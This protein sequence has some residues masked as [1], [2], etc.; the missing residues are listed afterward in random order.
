MDLRKLNNYLKREFIGS[1]ALKDAHVLDMGCGAGGDF[2]KWREALVGH[3]V[4]ADPSSGAIAEARKRRHHGPD[5]LEFVTGEIGRV[6]VRP[7]DFIFWNFSLQYT[8]DSEDH[9]DKTIREMVTR[10][11]PG[12]IIAGVIPDS[13]RI[14]M[15]PVNFYEDFSGN[16][17]IKGKVNGE[18]G[19]QVSFFVKG[20]PYYRR[21]PI[22]EPVAWRDLLVTRMD[23]AGFELDHWG[24]FSTQTTGLLTDLYSTF[25][26]SF[27]G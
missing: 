21:G 17:V 7:Y 11:H 10:S 15:L 12:T 23:K 8:F 16:Q 26:F 27:R 3:L 24:P 18:I 5:S 22:E 19:D 9:L 6:P 20:A 25:A 2:H 1:F 13:H 14:F 4:A